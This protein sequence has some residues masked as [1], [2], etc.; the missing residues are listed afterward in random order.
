[1]VHV[2][3]TRAFVDDRCAGTTAL[4]YVHGGPGQGAYDFMASVADRLSEHVRV[5]GV[6]QRGCLR[7]DPMPED[8]PISHEV[9]IADFEAVR[10]HLGIKRWLLVGHSAGGPIALKYALTHPETVA[11]VYFLCA[12]FDCDLTDRYRLPVAA[13]LL[14]RLGKFEAATRCEELVALTRRIT[15]TDESYLPMRELDEGYMRLFTHDQAG[16]DAYWALWERSGL[17]EEQQDRGQSHHPLLGQLY[18]P[19]LGLLPRLAQ[20]QAFVAHLAPLLHAD[21]TT[22]E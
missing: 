18:E 7:S 19:T 13:R 15:A 3:G 11:S 16:A 10:R 22:A 1:M 5:V 21:L 14:R 8:P 12:T 4:L 6:D 17:S 2:S 9:L 20:P